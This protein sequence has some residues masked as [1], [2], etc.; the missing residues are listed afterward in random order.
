MA[1]L[2]S[3]TPSTLVVAGTGAVNLTAAFTALAANT[4][5][6]F[7]NN[8]RRVLAVNVDGTTSIATSQIGVTVQAQ[9]VTGVSSGVL[10]GSAISIL[11]PWPIAFDR[12]D[13]SF[14]VEIDFSSSAGVTVALLEIPGVV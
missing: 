8:G 5:V 4:G 7:V 14:D 10:P 1:Q 11:G 12:T 13:G 6:L 9:P 3:L 2:L